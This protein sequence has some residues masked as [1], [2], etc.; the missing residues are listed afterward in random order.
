MHLRPLD[1]E[2]QGQSVRPASQVCRRDARRGGDRAPRQIGARPQRRVAAGY[3]PHG[4][5]SVNF[6][7]VLTA[8]K[9]RIARAQFWLAVLVLAA[10]SLVITSLSYVMAGGG[11]HS[12]DDYPTM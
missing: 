10:A 9:G 4:E 2:P 7:R 8:Y 1:A 5:I 3:R 11:W 12:N 6:W